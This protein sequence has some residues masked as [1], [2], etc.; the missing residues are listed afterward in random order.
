MSIIVKY[1]R[2]HAY[3]IIYLFPVDTDSELFRF[4]I[5]RM[6]GFQLRIQSAQS[7]NAWWKGIALPKSIWFIANQIFITYFIANRF[8]LINGLLTDIIPFVIN[9][10][11][12][13]TNAQRKAK[14]TAVV[15]KAKKV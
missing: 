10:N 2:K 7:V 8:I 12:S 9:D 13:S 5:G 3:Y 15:Q 1:V 14:F 11:I 4:V 6:H